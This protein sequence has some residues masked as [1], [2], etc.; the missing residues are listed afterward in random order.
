MLMD[1]G[2]DTGA[3]L[4]KVETSVTLWDNAHTLA[5]KL[6]DLGAD[7]L[8]DTLQQLPTI[9]PTPQDHSLA[10][11]AP[12]IQ[13]SEYQIDWTRSSIALHNQVRGFYPNC[14]T[15]LRE[16]PLKVIA[17]APLDTR[18]RSQLPPEI[19]KILPEIDNLPT[20]HTPGEIVYLAKGLGP[21]IATGDG[22][23]LLQEVQ[24]PGKRPQSGSDLVNGSRLE[25]GEKLG[26]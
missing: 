10:T 8:I 26:R 18:S 9:T 5:V 22:C 11:H 6:A 21:V 20:T 23:L 15:T 3:M 14:H 16:Q 4:L 24:L 25:I 19:Q 12:P 1:A 13:K 17:T 7:L 2:M